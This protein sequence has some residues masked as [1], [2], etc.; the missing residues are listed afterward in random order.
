[1]KASIVKNEEGRVVALEVSTLENL[2]AITRVLERATGVSDVRRQFSM[3]TPLQFFCGNVQ[4][5]VF[6][7]WGDS[8]SYQIFPTADGVPELSFYTLLDAF[9]SYK[10]VFQ[11]IAGWFSHNGSNYANS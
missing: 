7:A 10:T 4:W 1:M 9:E 8:E 5:L 2:S 6:D 3:D 11:R